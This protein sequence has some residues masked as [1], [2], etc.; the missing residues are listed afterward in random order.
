[1]KA[2]VAAI[3]AMSSLLVMHQTIVRREGFRLE[4]I[5]HLQGRF[6]GTQQLSWPEVSETLD[7]TSR[8]RLISLTGTRGEICQALLRARLARSL[9]KTLER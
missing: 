8:M 6:G 3:P 2:A 5:G 4:Q 1:M 7:V 9:E